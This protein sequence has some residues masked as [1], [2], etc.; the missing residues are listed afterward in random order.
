MSRFLF[1]TVP[2]PAHSRNPLPI[3][4]RL[5]E[6]GHEVLW[7]ASRRFHE[8][9][10]AV[11]ATPVPYRR[12]A[13]LRRRAAARGVP[14]ARRAAAGRGRSAGRTPSCSSARRAHRVADLE[15]VLGAAPVDAVLSDGAELRRRAA[16]ASR[17]ASRPRR[18]AT[19]AGPGPRRD[20]GVR[21]GPAADARPGVAAAQP[22]RA[23]GVPALGLRAGAGAAT[24]GC[25]PRLGLPPDGRTCSRP[26]SR[27]CCTC[28]P[29]RRRSSTRWRT[30]RP[31]CTG[32]VPCGR[33]RRRT[34]RR[35]VVGRGAHLDPARRA[36]DPGQH[37]ARTCA[38]SWC[39][40][41]APSSRDD[42]LV[43]VTTGGVPAP[44]VEALFGGPLPGNVRVSRLH[45]L[46]RCCC[47]TS[48]CA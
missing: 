39:P 22:R 35:R 11:G 4:A 21:P 34:G 30:C 19:A 6:R 37:P 25:A 7:F 32:W 13:R 1:A 42:V 17:A 27:R 43:V 14:R 24:T 48:T 44:A 45:P 20:P 28:R 3:A 5:V 38:S 8:G 15:P 10:A 36:R 47:R 23:R 29:A 33:T 16:R 41:S 18:S 26:R 9:I 46:R 40:R 31:P 2:V 12:H